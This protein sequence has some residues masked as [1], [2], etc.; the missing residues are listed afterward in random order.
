LKLKQALGKTSESGDSTPPEGN[1]VNVSATDKLN[2]YYKG[3]I[4]PDLKGGKKAPKEWYKPEASGKK[5][6]NRKITAGF[7]IGALLIIGG[8]IVANMFIKGQD[9]VPAGAMGISTGNSTNSNSTTTPTPSPTKNVS[10]PKPT[11]NPDN[12]TTEVCTSST[13]TSYNRIISLSCGTSNVYDSSTGV[14]YSS[15]EAYVINSWTTMSSSQSIVSSPV[16]VANYRQWPA[17]ISADQTISGHRIQ[18]SEAGSYMITMSFV[19]PFPENSTRVFSVLIQNAV[20]VSNLA[21]SGLYTV[22]ST[23]TVDSSRTLAIDF[24]ASVGSSPLMNAL[25]IFFI[26]T[27]STACP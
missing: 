27:T 1:S 18:L 9:K 2:A 19:E 14:A 23:A 13:S 4:V 20:A 7:L 26:N 15:D 8:G 25:E 24:M 5:C 17:S 3:N 21:L 12:G 10:T 6:C 22:N 16:Y 11:T